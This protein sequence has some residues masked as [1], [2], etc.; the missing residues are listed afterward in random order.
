MIPNKSTIP[1]LDDS[2]IYILRVGHHH[3]IH[4]VEPDLIRQRDQLAPLPQ[5]GSRSVLRVIVVTSLWRR[6][7]T[8]GV[9]VAGLCSKP[10]ILH[11]IL[12]KLLEVVFKH[13]HALIAEDHHN[14]S[15][16]RVTGNLS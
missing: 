1:L 16:Q 14:I 7:L 15:V 8:R 10:E 2:P 12:D 3:L 5:G 6:H 11:S 4:A 9:L 13:E